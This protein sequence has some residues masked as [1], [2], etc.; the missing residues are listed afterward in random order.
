MTQSQFLEAEQGKES[1]PV[2]GDG[3]MAWHGV[4]APAGCKGNLPGWGH[5]GEGHR[6]SEP[7]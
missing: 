6:V 2:A 4:L 7:K 1:V 3:E 5:G